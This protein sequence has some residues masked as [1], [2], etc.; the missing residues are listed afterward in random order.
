M[1]I[2]KVKNCR[3]CEYSET[4]ITESTNPTL[5]YEHWCTFGKFFRTKEG[6]KQRALNHKIRYLRTNIN[7][8]PSWCPLEVY[9]C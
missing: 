3:E 8:F 2:I 7:T 9:K 1:K 6:F 5:S 4:F